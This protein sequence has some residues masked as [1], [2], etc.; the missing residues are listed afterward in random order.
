MLLAVFATVAYFVVVIIYSKFIDGLRFFARRN[1]VLRVTYID[2]TGS[3]RDVLLS[4][5]RLGFQIQG[6]TTR[7]ADEAAQ[8]GVLNRLLGDE[9]PA[10]GSGSLVEVELEIEG[11]AAK[12]VL[13]GELAKMATITA[14]SFDDENE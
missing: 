8:G 12:D 4:C 9:S 11:P 6:F 13:L 3:L 10:D 1:H 5:T 14:V 2:G 7:R